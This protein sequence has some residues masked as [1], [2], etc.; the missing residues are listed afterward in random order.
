MSAL[1]Q[2]MSWRNGCVIANIIEK[3][4]NILIFEAVK[5]R[6]YIPK[7]NRCLLEMH[8]LDSGHS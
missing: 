2:F 8:R 5:C 1:S 3:L 6:K 7:I 4:P